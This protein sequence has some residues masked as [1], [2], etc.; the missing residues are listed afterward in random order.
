MKGNQFK[1]WNFEF[2]E[3]LREIFTSE[4]S[5]TLTMETEL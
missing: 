2:R 4:K 3:K 1:S 5:Q